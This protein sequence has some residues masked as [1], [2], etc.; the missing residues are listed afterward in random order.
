MPPPRPPSGGGPVVPIVIAAVVLVLVVIGAGAF[1]LLAAGDDDDD[2]TRRRLSSLP[3]STPSSL[4][5]DGPTSSP[6]SHPSFILKPTVTSSQGNTFTRVGVRTES[7]T[8]RAN[9][10]LQRRL[11]SYPCTDQL[12]SAVYANSSRTIVTVIS[13]LEVADASSANL[14]SSATYSEGW[15]QLL[16]PSSGSGLEVGQ[17]SEYW[18]RS[19]PVGNHVVYAQSYWASGAPPGGRTGSVYLTG[20]ELGQEITG[21][22]RSGI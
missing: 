11:R 21:E 2:D 13:I 5:T 10:T 20:G 22:V 9:A 14:V 8:S 12:Y 16:K 1:V 7:C 15:P 4:T 17:V 19:W 6:G 3:T 18:T